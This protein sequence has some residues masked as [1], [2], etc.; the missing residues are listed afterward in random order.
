MLDNRESEQ[1]TFSTKLDP[2][3]Q[4]NI[5]ACARE[6]GSKIV[7]RRAIANRFRGSQHT[8]ALPSNTIHLAD[9]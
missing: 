2:F 7:N 6:V 3:L 4:S 9:L 1:M 5:T 8:M